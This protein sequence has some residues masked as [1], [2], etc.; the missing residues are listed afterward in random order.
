MLG[1]TYLTPRRRTSCLLGFCGIRTWFAHVLQIFARS[2]GGGFMYMLKV[3]PELWTLS[4][5]HRTQIVYGVDI[6][7][8]LMR[9]GVKPG[10][11]VIESGTGSGSLTASFAR[12]VSPSGHVHTFEFNEGRVLAAQAEFKQLGVSN[13]TFKRADACTDGFGPHLDNTIDC[14]LLDLPQPWLAIPHAYR[15]MKPYSSL[16]CYS[17]CIEQVSR[18]CAKLRELGFEDIL[19]VEA[20]GRQHEVAIDAIHRVEIEV[21]TVSRGGE[22]SGSKRRRAPP[23]TSG[24]A[25]ETASKVPRTTATTTVPTPTTATAAGTSA[26]EAR[27]VVEEDEEVEA[28]PL[29]FAQCVPY[30]AWTKTGLPMSV[31]QTAFTRGHTAYLT[32]AWLY[33]K[34]V[35]VVDSGSSAA[36]SL[37]TGTGILDASRLKE[38]VAPL[39]T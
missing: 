20:L 10:C 35:V 14:V 27:V 38:S 31:K 1:F 21:P 32:F 24:S 29:S 19:T 33:R 4:L 34:A 3:T 37:T 5:T 13:V 28:A 7:V 23:A 30:P 25:S 17:P 36:S 8:I 9:L 15:S 18:N 2:S 6:A 39:A 16:C 12:A 26:R 11:Q 22:G